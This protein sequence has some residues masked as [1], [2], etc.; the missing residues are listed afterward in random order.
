MLE[1]LYGGPEGW[2]SPPCDRLDSLGQWSDAGIPIPLGWI[3]CF[4]GPV[5]FSV[6]V[7]PT[8]WVGDFTSMCFY[9]LPGNAD[10]MD[11]TRLDS[12]VETG[13]FGLAPGGRIEL[14]FASETAFSQVFNVISNF[15]GDQML[16]RVN[17]PSSDCSDLVP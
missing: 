1:L 4:P 3:G 8:S 9:A 13:T 2:R 7:Q 12:G 17:E 15:P 11:L 6:Y 14:N 5:E 10:F 16:M